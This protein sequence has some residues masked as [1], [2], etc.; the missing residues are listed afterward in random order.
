MT[1]F[2]VLEPEAAATARTNMLKLPGDL[3]A[4]ID[5][6]SAPADG[7]G[8]IRAGAVEVTRQSD[9]KN[10]VYYRRVDATIKA[11]I[12]KQLGLADNTGIHY[13]KFNAKRGLFGFLY[14]SNQAPSPGQ[15]KQ[16]ITHHSLDRHLAIQTLLDLQLKLSFISD[17]E[18]RYEIAPVELNADIYLGMMLSYKRKDESGVFDALRYDV[19]F[20]KQQEIAISLHRVVMEFSPNQ[21]TISRPVTE[22]GTLIFDWAGKRYQFKHRLSATTN[23]NRNYMAFTSKGD[24]VKA[25]DRY[26]N[27][28][29]YHQTDCLNRIIRIL[30]ASGVDSS[31]VVFQASHQIK[32]FLDG[33]PAPSNPLWVLDTTADPQ[34]KGS[35]DSLA[36]AFGAAK[37]LS[38]DDLPA[39][40]ELVE[41]SINYLVI[42]EMLP[43]AG[44]SIVEKSSMKSFNT[45]W[46]ALAAKQKNPAADF[47]Y[48]TAAKIHRFI[49]S[50][51]SICQGFDL[52]PGKAPSQAAI[53]KSL[54]ELALKEAI[55]K[56]GEVII[57]GANLPRASLELIACRRDKKENVFYQVLDV[58]VLGESIMIEKIQRYDQFSKGEFNHDFIQLKAVLGKG[59]EN[60]FDA[61]WNDTFLIHDK[62]TNAWLSSYNTSRV[63]AIIGNALFDNQER[64]DS[65]ISPSREVGIRVSALP[66]YLTP[67]RQKQRHSVFIQDNGIDGAWFFVASNKP[68]N[69]TISKQ[70][71]VYNI[72]ITDEFGARVPVLSHPLG[73]LFFSTFTFDIVKLRE[74]AKTSI[75]QKIVELCLHN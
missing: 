73:E 3:E 19:Y 7:V 71:L 10:D 42:S 11:V 45:F 72:V 57:A 6:L 4:I 52:K 36:K 8:H 49:N 12:R 65:G 51:A 43:I 22:S 56:R 58:A 13:S 28:I 27:S 75:L 44:S 61:I 26:E 46:Q 66:Y 16:V 53:E 33:V 60:P 31:Q 14:L 34:R 24:E 54:Q 15:V 40:T 35:V 1:L 18:K 48:Y 69:N 50:K 74:S 17:V 25:P 21:D 39:P 5:R 32:A 62:E 29:N 37:V 59:S 63:P 68:A 64:Q 70:S 67:T 47:D 23:S 30:A 2:N 55:F 9:E 20:S 41:K 38:A